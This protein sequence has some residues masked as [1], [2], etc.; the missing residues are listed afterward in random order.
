M[1]AELQESNLL[2]A[3]EMVFDD[4]ELSLMLDFTGIE[5]GPAYS[6]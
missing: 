6:S 2:R 4:E 5:A 1:N 3:H